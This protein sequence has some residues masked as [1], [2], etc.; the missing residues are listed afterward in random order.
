MAKSSAAFNKLIGLGVRG[1]PLKSVG[2][3][4]VFQTGL[5]MLRRGPSTQPSAARAGSIQ[6]WVKVPLMSLA[7]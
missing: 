7:G 6:M 5:S 1:G 2:D 3:A 4:S